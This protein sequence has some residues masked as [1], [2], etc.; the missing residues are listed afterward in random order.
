[1]RYILYARKST[2]DKGRQILSLESQITEMTRLAE[3][4]DLKIVKI[5][6]ESKSAKKP[7]NRPLFAQ[8]IKMLERGE[9]EGI[10]C[11]KIDR[12]SRNPIDSGMIQWL[13]QQGNIKAIQTMEKQYLPSDNV[14]LFNVES[15]MANQYILDLSKNVKRG[16]KAKLEKGGWPCKA[17]LG[18]LNNRLDKTIFI[19]EKR[20]AYIVKAFLLY[21]TGTHSLKDITN[22]L[23]EEGL[24]SVRGYKVGKSHIH[25]ILTQPFYYGVMFKQGKYYQGGHEPLITKNLFDKVNDL[26]NNGNRSRAKNKFFTFRGFMTCANCGCLLT[27]DNKKGHDYYYCTNGKKICDEHKKYLRAEKIENMVSEIFSK[28]HFDEDLIEIAFEAYKEKCKLNINYNETI[29]ENLLKQLESL[30]NKKDKLLDTYLAEMI[31]REAFEAKTMALNNELIALEAQ[32]KNSKSKTSE[33]QNTFEPVKKVFLNANLAKKQFLNSDN[34][35][36]RKILENLLSNLSISNNETANFKLKMPYQI[37]VEAPLKRDLTVMLRDL[38]SN[39]D[40]RLQRAMSYR[41][42]IPH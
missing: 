23:Y 18:Y 30:K 11:W 28:L 41:W 29:K 9:A 6:Q 38:D 1:M 12:L 34:L 32:I 21:S 2:E 20:S 24:R 35:N 33:G 3:N 15:G 10:L 27:A 4:L 7:D 8:M 39:Q 37:L 16:N 26:M 31:A 14:I 42:T 22:I 13:M 36:K 19:D 40:T 5:F 25:H 17:P